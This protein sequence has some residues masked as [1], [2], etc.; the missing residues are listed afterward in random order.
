MTDS[1]LKLMFGISETKL[2]ILDIL[3]KHCEKTGLDNIPK[4][5]LVEMRKQL[6]IGL[7]KEFEKEKIL[8]TS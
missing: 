6:S 8:A 3:I 2:A 7:T 1:E 5:D 4:K